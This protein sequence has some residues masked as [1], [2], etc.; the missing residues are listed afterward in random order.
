MSEVDLNATVDGYRGS[1]GNLVFKKYKGRIIVC[2]KPR[3]TKPPSPL[4]VAERA[5]FSEAVA[6]AR[7][8][9]ADPAARAFYEPIARERDTCVYWLA[10]KDFRRAPSIQPLDLS[11]YKGRC[12]DIIVIQAVDVIGLAEMTV[13]IV[14]QDGTPIESGD[15]VE[16]GV[17]SGKWIY[18]ATAQVA[19][20]TEV[21][22]EVQGADHAG[23][24]VQLSENYT[25]GVDH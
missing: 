11:N 9:K 25:V 12:G 15:A 21:F 23:N 7:G 13:S 3:F 24:R 10:I 5:N 4:Q 14:A 22:I 8:V 17:R 16:Q 20:G 1:I 2:R 6:Y 19:L 18:T